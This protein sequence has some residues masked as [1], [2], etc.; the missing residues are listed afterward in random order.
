M[1]FDAPDGQQLHF[2]LSRDPAEVGKQT[3]AQVC[4][5]RFTS[6]L[7]AENDVKKRTRVR[8]THGRDRNPVAPPGL[9]GIF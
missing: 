9:G 2:V 1:V 7:G 8:V 6:I 4:I 5:Q 3:L